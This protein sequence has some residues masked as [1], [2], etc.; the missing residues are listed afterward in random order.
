MQ[1]THGKSY[2]NCSITREWGCHVQVHYRKVDSKHAEAQYKP[3][4]GEYSMC[5]ALSLT[6]SKWNTRNGTLQACGQTGFTA[7]QADHC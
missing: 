6:Y 3:V 4:I 7:V 5:R 1:L 2:N